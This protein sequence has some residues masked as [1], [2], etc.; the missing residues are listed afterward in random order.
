LYSFGN[1]CH[2]SEKDTESLAI[3]DSTGQSVKKNDK[4]YQI[5][6]GC[7]QKQDGSIAKH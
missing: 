4:Y 1:T 3:L 2:L 6:K 5:I 7:L